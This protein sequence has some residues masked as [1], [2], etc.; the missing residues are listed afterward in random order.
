[1][2][3]NRKTPW[4]PRPTGVSLVQCPLGCTRPPETWNSP[5]DSDPQQKL[6]NH[7]R[8]SFHLFCLFVCL[9]AGVRLLHSRLGAH[10]GQSRRCLVQGRA[11]RHLCQTRKNNKKRRK[12]CKVFRKESV[13]RAGTPII[14]PELQVKVASVGYFVWAFYTQDNSSASSDLREGDAP[15]G[16]GEALEHVRVC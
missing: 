10:A 4:L 2:H 5:V 14:V 16:G 15:D 3:L 13:C 1:M 11:A 7:L 8:R 9:P 12:L 6:V